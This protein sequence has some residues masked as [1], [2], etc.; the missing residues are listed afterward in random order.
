MSMPGFT[1]GASL[2]PQAN[3]RVKYISGC[4]CFPMYCCELFRGCGFY[5]DLCICGT[6]TVGYEDTAA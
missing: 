3:L 5:C 2:Q 6:F 1:A 4:F